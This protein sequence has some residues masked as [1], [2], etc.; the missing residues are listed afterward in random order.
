M[1]PAIATEDDL[2]FWLLVLIVAYLAISFLVH[3]FTT[4]WAAR[5]GPNAIQ[6]VFD[7]STFAASS[8]II[9]GIITPHVLTLIGS[10]KPFLAIGGLMG[11]IYSIQAL[12]PRD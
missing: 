9:W 4:P 6:R 12:F 7:A 11:I 10:T 5:N 1:L 2:Y 8:L 3:G